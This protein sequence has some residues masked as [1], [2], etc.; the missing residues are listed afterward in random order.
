MDRAT[1]IKARAAVGHRENENRGPTTTDDD[2]GWLLKN[3]RLTW[4]NSALRGESG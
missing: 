1:N 3:P 4:A 2:T